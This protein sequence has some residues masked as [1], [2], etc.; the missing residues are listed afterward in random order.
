MQE[1]KLLGTRSSKIVGLLDVA[2]GTVRENATSTRLDNVG[3]VIVVVIGLSDNV[4][5]DVS[6][7]VSDLRE[8]P[9]GFPDGPH[10]VVCGGDQS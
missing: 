5:C 6:R 3:L 7:I 1:V 10:E 2:G 8:P 4:D 9:D